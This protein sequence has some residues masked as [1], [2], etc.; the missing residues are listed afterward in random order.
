ME[1]SR[2]DNFDSLSKI[3]TAW[4]DL[5]KENISEVPFLAFEYLQAWWETR[6][7]G[8][9]PQDSELVIITA[10]ENNNLIGVAPFFFSNNLDG[11]PA[12]M[13]VGAIEVSDFLDFLVRPSELSEF[14]AG[15][16]DFLE[17]ST[18][19]PTWEALDLHNILEDS[20]TLP[21]LAAEAQRR[22]W[23]HEQMRLQPSPFIPLPGDFDAYLAQIDKKQRHEI[24]R[25]MRNVEQSLAEPGYYTVTDAETLTDETQAFIDMMAQDPSKKAFLTDA[26]VEHLHNTAKV[27]FDQ[28]WLHL[29]FF[30]LDGNK[31]AGNFSFIYNNRLWLY[32]SAWEWEYRE[33][34]PGWVLLT[35]LLQW[36]NEN[37]LEEFDFMR[38]DE[39]YKYKFGG[40]DRYIYRVVVTI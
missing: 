37:G 39:A 2:Y 10:T 30:T 17:Y 15:L 24:R 26:M 25:K 31:A 5:L 34:S 16:L 7:G 13:F 11:K 1:F 29:G 3:K 38:G 18:D 6:G 23:N 8:E 14:L 35:H 12:L 20:P 28:G 9:W 4:N 32:N 27:M 19:L 22:G 33:F 36:A 21:A 40:Q